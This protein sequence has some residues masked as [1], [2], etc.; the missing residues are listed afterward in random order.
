M[1]RYDWARV[2]HLQL[3]RY[4]EYLVK[5]ELTL[6][7]CDVYG[8][9]VDDKGI[10]LVFRTAKGDYYDV[11]VKSVYRSSYIFMAK[12][13]FVPRAGLLVA[14]ILCRDGCAPD[15]YL[16]PS[17]VWLGPNALFV[18]RD[19]IGKKSRPEWGI[20]L[21]RRNLP[22]LEPYRLEETIRRL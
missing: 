12:A 3:G 2:S 17:T 6:W 7:G 1:D 19:Y 4:A 11:Q 14:V 10:D 18:S 9:K 20:Q 21:S 8:A 22:L 16:V 5:M 15:A 13:F